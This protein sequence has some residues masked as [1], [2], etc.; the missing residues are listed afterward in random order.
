MAVSFDADKAYM[1]ADPSPPAVSCLLFPGGPFQW[2]DAVS[3]SAQ[4]KST[5]PKSSTPKNSQP[6]VRRRSKRKTLAFNPVQ[7]LCVFF[8]RW[9]KRRHHG[10]FHRFVY[11]VYVPDLEAHISIF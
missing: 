6:E 8:S 10:G 4:A 5:P 7:W 11:S 3:N 2:C 9:Q 1:A